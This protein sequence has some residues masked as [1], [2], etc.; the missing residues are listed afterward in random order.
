VKTFCEACSPPRIPRFEGRNLLLEKVACNCKCSET[1]FESRG[2]R[3]PRCDHPVK[4]ELTDK[5][6]DPFLW[7]DPKTHNP[8]RLDEVGQHE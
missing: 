5:W 3:C 6:D 8:I 7:L 2:P 1:I 4:I